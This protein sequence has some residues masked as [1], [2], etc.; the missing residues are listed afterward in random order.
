MRLA[1]LIVIPALFFFIRELQTA[2]I[3]WKVILATGVL[4]RSD[5]TEFKLQRPRDAMAPAKKLVKRIDRAAAQDTARPAT[6]R[7]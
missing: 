2:D 7:T 1:A 6:A 5:D 3:D 4:R